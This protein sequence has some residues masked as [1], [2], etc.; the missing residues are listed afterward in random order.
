ML[1]RAAVTIIALAAVPSAASAQH[2]TGAPF[3]DAFRMIARH[4]EADPVDTLNFQLQRN[5][6]AGHQVLTPDG[7]W[8]PSTAARVCEMLDTYSVISGVYPVEMIKS[9]SDVDEFIRWMGAMARANL[10]PGGEAPD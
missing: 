5:A 6:V 7:V 2:C 10:V 3:A 8:G 4:F 9:E 1:F